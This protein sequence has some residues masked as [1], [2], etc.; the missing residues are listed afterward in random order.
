M[1]AI[2]T[3]A[4]IRT[5]ALPE[6]RS[7]QKLFIYGFH[8]SETPSIRF[9]LFCSSAIVPALPLL[10][11]T[12]DLCRTDMGVYGRWGMRYSLHRCADPGD[13]MAQSSSLTSAFAVM[14]AFMRENMK[15]KELI[16]RPK[17]IHSPSFPRMVRVSRES[18]P[19]VA[20]DN[21]SVTSASSDPISIA[22]VQRIKAMTSESSDLL[23][24][25]SNEA[26]G[27]EPQAL[28]SDSK[29]AVAGVSGMSFYTF[30]S[31]SRKLIRSLTLR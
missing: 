5:C 20:N 24:V 28:R 30:P 26:S 6:N 3:S 12:P 1:H 8:S 7:R 4:R 21:I 29:M 2:S 11:Y 31:S 25:G 10:E 23:S 19:I 9:H 14:Y 18:T 17:S 15:A 22:R 27:W 16:G 13:G